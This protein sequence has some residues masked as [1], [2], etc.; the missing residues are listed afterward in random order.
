MSYFLFSSFPLSRCVP[1]SE[2]LT[3]L[4]QVGLGAAIWALDQFA[5]KLWSKSVSLFQVKK[6]L[7]FWKIQILISDVTRTRVH[8]LTNPG[9]PIFDP[10]WHFLFVMYDWDCDRYLGIVQEFDVENDSRRWISQML[11]PTL[12]LCRLQDCCSWHSLFPCMKHTWY[13]VLCTIDT[14]KTKFKVPYLLTTPIRNAFFSICPPCFIFFHLDN[15]VET[16]W[17]SS[18]DIAALCDHYF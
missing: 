10:G 17:F 14:E 11:G 9:Q 13:L 8:V 7:Y 6:S 16:T 5:A 15:F 2:N 3:I 12:T 4:Y 1:L 18:D